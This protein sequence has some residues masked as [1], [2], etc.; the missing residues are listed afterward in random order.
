M[1]IITAGIAYENRLAVPIYLNRW[2]NTAMVTYADKQKIREISERYR[3]KR[4][5]LF[6][7]GLH[8]EK[9]GR[10]IDIGVEGI[11]P[12]DFFS[13][14]GEL[15]FALSKPVDIVDLSVPSKF[16]QLVRQEGTVIYG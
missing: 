14:Y 12:A 9:K 6:G 1:S 16:V 13:Y 8:P 7:S 15:M 10:D 3:V 4:V 11:S 2:Y 5:F